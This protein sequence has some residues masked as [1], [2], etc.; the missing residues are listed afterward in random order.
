MT[1][2][3]LSTAERFRRHQRD[4]VA[5]RQ[6]SLFR[7]SHER[8][9]RD[10]AIVPFPFVLAGR[11]LRAP[12]WVPASEVLEA[13]RTEAIWTLD[14][15]ARQVGASGISRSGDLMA[16]L[17]VAVLGELVAAGQVGPPTGEAISID[18]VAP[19]PASLLIHPMDDKTGEIPAVRL[20]S[21][22][23]V[24]PWERLLRDLF[25]TLG[26]RP[27]LMN[28]L[29]ATYPAALAVAREGFKLHSGGDLPE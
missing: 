12:L 14:T 2:P 9:R 22:F 7:R 26:W 23:R 11:S 28:R 24:V 13:L 1:R 3:V 17:P 25:G 4:L 16:Y 5:Y 15:A 27:D 18:P 8:F 20:T 10:L 21:G 6:R 29:E 19:R